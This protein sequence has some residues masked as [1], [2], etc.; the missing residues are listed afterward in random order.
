MEHQELQRLAKRFTGIKPD[1]E[2]EEYILSEAEEQKAISHAINSAKEHLA[3]RMKDKNMKEGDILLKI[4]EIDWEQHID[5]EDVLQKCNSSK[6]YD[7]WQ[8]GQ[9]KNEIEEINKAQEELKKR[10]NPKYMFNV[11]A[12]TAKNTFGTELI[13]HED[14]KRVMKTICYF[15][16]EDKRFETDMIDVDG[17][18]A[19]YSLKK[20]LLLRGT[21][22]LGKTFLVTCCEHNELNPILVLSMI[23][24]ADEVKKNGEYLMDVQDRKIIY[25]DDVGT[26]ESPVNHFGTKINWFKNF[27]ELVYLKNKIFNKLILSTNCNF[28]QLE[29]KYGFRVR[30][31]M[32]EMFNLVDVAGRDMRGHTYE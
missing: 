23:E 9:R 2:K 20:G 27:I 19:N 14:N 26:E 18:P 11:M 10:C 24:I 21:T 5:R 8:K 32:R 4:S 30:S 17:K 3:W 6:H 29:E 16:S 7:L 15:L 13:L 28:A 31:R 12:W 22:G 25:M 1:E